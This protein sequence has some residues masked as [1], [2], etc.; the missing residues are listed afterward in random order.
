MV[1]GRSCGKHNARPS[2]GQGQQGR[3]G[4][5]LAAAELCGGG[6]N[7]LACMASLHGPRKA[8]WRLGVR[9]KAP[10]WEDSTLHAAGVI[11]M[12]GPSTRYFGP[13]PSQARVDKLRGSCVVSRHVIFR[14]LE[15]ASPPNPNPIFLVHLVSR[16]LGAPGTQY[17]CFGFS[18][19]S[20]GDGQTWDE[21]NKLPSPTPFQTW[22]VAHGPI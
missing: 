2:K 19:L 22:A 17:L 11:K 21:T 9:S 10:V 8:S 16:G 5:L 18:Y 4:V 14:K 6:L 1:A 13:V 15:P 7:G 12:V 20:S 3:V